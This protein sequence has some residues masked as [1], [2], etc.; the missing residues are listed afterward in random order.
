MICKY[1]DNEISDKL[2]ICI[3]CGNPVS[4][5]APIYQPIEAAKE[6]SPADNV[7]VSSS[8]EDDTNVI[9]ET[10]SSPVVVEVND[11]TNSYSNRRTDRTSGKSSAL[12]IILGIVGAIIVV[13][14]LLIVGVAVLGLMIEKQQKKE[15]SYATTDNEATNTKEDS[16][17]TYGYQNNTTAIPPEAEEEEEPVTYDEEIVEEEIEEEAEEDSVF[18]ED[19]TKIHDYEIIVSDVTWEEAVR[20]CSRRGGYLVRIN[21]LSEYD[22]IM[23]QIDR[24]GYTDKIFYLGGKLCEEDNHYHWYDYESGKYDKE[25]LDDYNSVFY[26]SWL[27]GEPS[28]TGEDSNG[29]ILDENYMDMFYRKKDDKFVWNDVPSDI[30]AVA[31]NYAGKVAYIC[32]KE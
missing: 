18:F 24:E 26:N 23:E 1:C 5:E 9:I 27:A 6:E 7:N 30:I 2:K 3:Y 29:N 15:T 17:Y 21:S 16:G 10:D 14:V 20:E 32:E 25:I 22:Y 28:F 13:V 31:P 19:E 4:G 11:N 8:E 12:P